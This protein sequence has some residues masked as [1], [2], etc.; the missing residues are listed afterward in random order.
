MKPSISDLWRWDDTVDRGPYVL[1]GV[2][3]FALKH[4]IDRFVASFVFNQKWSLFNY[5]SPSDVVI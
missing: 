2:V 5:I 3:L 4:N 1:I